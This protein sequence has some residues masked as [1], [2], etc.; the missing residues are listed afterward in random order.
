MKRPFPLVEIEWIDSIGGTSWHTLEDLLEIQDERFMVHRSAGY[1]V[2]QTDMSITL[3]GSYQEELGDNDGP[4]SRHVLGGTVIP[5]SAI[6][7][8]VKLRDDVA[9]VDAPSSR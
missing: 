4:E 1:V 5:R 8:V 9:D 6:R 7:S 3:V 2:R